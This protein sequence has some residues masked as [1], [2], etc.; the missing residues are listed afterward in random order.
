VPADAAD[1]VVAAVRAA[2]ATAGRRLFGDTPVHFPLTPRV[3]DG[4]DER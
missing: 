2:A 1:D 3:V 4:Y